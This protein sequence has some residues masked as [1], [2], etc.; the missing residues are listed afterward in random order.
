VIDL[1]KATK[2]K[3]LMFLRRHQRS[4]VQWITTALQTVNSKTF[5]VSPST[6]MVVP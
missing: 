3:H 6:R 4:A 2:L 1:S 5:K